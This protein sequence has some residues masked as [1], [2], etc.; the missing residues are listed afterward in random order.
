MTYARTTTI[1][2]N[3]AQKRGEIRGVLVTDGEASDGHILNIRGA[4]IDPGLPLVWSHD[5]MGRGKQLL[6]I[7]CSTRDSRLSK[8]GRRITIVTPSVC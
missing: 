4:T 7:S 5:A 8:R 6:A 3:G 2:R 1:S